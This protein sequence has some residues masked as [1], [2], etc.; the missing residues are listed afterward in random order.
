MKTHLSY[1]VDMAAA[2]GRETHGVLTYK[3]VKNGHKIC[4]LHLKHWIQ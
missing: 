3:K 4:N 2:D 1:K